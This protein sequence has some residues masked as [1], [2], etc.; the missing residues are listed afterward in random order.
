MEFE[1]P[2]KWWLTSSRNMDLNSDK[3]LDLTY[4]CRRKVLA[5]RE[6]EIP[7]TDRILSDRVEYEGQSLRSNL[8]KGKT[9]EEVH[10]GDR[11]RTERGRREIRRVHIPG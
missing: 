1:L 3:S 6:C 9:E 10:R 11:G 2:V 8:L 7:D 4:T 5:C